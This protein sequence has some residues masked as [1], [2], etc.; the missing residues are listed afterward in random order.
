MQIDVKEGYTLPPADHLLLSLS[1]PASYL[2]LKAQEH[3]GYSFDPL[4]HQTETVL[5]FFFWSADRLWPEKGRCNKP[6][7]LQPGFFTF[8]I[9]F[10][11]IIPQKSQAS[12]TGNVA[13]LLSD[14]FSVWKESWCWKIVLAEGIGWFVLKEPQSPLLLQGPFEQL[15]WRSV[16]SPPHCKHG[17]PIS[18]S[19][20]WLPI[21]KAINTANAVKSGEQKPVHKRVAIWHWGSSSYSDTDCMKTTSE[22]LLSIKRFTMHGN[23][24][25]CGPLPLQTW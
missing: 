9:P 7:D 17:S 3:R 25:P 21:L 6:S 13:S 22:T 5:A 19:F 12:C 18:G 10:M 20:S 11:R 15:L 24:V 8:F 14:K 16:K 4:F 23:M 1:T 2:P